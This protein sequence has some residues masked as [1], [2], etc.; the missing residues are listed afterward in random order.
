MVV[1]TGGED[2]WRRREGTWEEIAIDVRD[3]RRPDLVVA[4]DEGRVDATAALDVL[5]HS[6]CVLQ[7]D[8]E[9]H[10]ARFLVEPWDALEEAL[11]LHT[12]PDAGALRL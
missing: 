11:T 7:G 8:T 1:S 6:M 9:T 12:C 10:P 2:S 4:G 3:P 5:V